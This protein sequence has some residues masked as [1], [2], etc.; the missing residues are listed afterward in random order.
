MPIAIPSN[1]LSFM[2]GFQLY[3]TSWSFQNLSNGNLPLKLFTDSA[4]TIR[5]RKFT[6]IIPDMIL[7]YC[8]GLS[9]YTA[10]TN[11]P[12]IAVF[13]E[14]LRQFL[15][16]LNQIYRHSSVPKNTSP[17]IFFSVL[18][19]AVSEHGAAATF[20]VTLWIARCSES[21]NCLTLA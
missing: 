16:A 12:I 6:K 4:L 19:Q 20:F 15:I 3:L 18:A 7:S 11:L 14:Y 2:S 1:T 5:K 13:V 10:I 17:W 9:R 21:F 8:I